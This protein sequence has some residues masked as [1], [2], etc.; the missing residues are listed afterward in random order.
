MIK[1]LSE[2]ATVKVGSKWLV[3][4]AILIAKHRGK[5]VIYIDGEGNEVHQ[6]PLCKSQFKGIK[7]S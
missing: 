6:E 4:K 5:A 7:L 1:V 2:Q 3:L